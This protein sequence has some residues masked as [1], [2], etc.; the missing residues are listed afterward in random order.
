MLRS[1]IAAAALTLA[2]SACRPDLPKEPP[3]S[4][5]VTAVFDPTAAVPQIPLPNDLVFLSNPNSVCPPPGND[6]KSGPACAQAELLTAFAGRFPSDQEIP[7]TIDFVQTNFN[8]DGTTSPSAP[9]LDFATFTPATLIVKSTTDPVGDVELDPIT[10][11]DYHTFADHATLSL[12]RKGR[13][14]WAPGSYAVI[15]RGGP[16]GVQTTDKVPVSASQVFNLIEQGLDMTDPKNIGLLKAQAGS[17]A[18]AL[19]QGMQ[20]NLL[21]GLYKGKLFPFADAVFPHQEMAIAT[22]FS[23][24]S[25][26]T[27]VTIDPAR[28]LAP[29]PFDLLRDLK[30]GKLSAL[31]AC[32]FAGSKLAADGTCPTPAAAG[33]L[34]LDGFSTTG[35]IL[36]PTSDLI[37]AA[38]VTKDTL[39]LYDL[40]DPNNPA[41]VPPET[42]II[43]PCEFGSACSPTAVS[44]VIAL[45]PAGA[46]AGD[47]T[48]VLRTKPLKDNTDYAVVITTGIKDKAGNSIG[49]GTVAKVLGF[50]NPVSVGGKSALQGI[51]DATAASLEA[52]RNQLKPVF[53]KV[54]KSEVALAY[55]FHT[56][57]ILGQA[58][59]LAALPYSTP[60]ETA[61]TGPLPD[62]VPT[63][64]D[65]FTKFGV[66]AGVPSGDINEILETDI[67]T[68]NA[69]DPAT[70]AFLADPTKAVPE[71]IHVLVATPKTAAKACAFN[72]ALKCAPMVVFRHGL[73]RGRA[74]LLLIAEAFASA[75][76][77]T[78]A[79]DA[80]K[81][82]DRALCTSGTTGTT[83]VAGG[84][85]IGGCNPGI[86]C[87]TDLPAGAQ[88]DAA[89]PGHCADGKLFKLGLDG[90]P[91][92]TPDKDGIPA[93]SSNYLISANFFRTRDTLR[94]DLIDESQLVRALAFVP[95]ATG[96]PSTVFAHMAAQGLVID[97]GTVYYVGQS[98]GSIQGSMNVATNPR[99]LKAAFNVGGGTLVDIF[100]QAPRFKPATDQLLAGLGIV[101][102][103][104]QFLQF[105]VVAKTVL[106]PA[107]PINFAGHLT[108]NT[109]ANLLMPGTLQPKRAVLAQIADCD[110]TVPNPFN[111]VFASN[112]GVSPLPTGDAFFTSRT[113]GT[114]Q[115]FISSA[116]QTLA[117]F[118]ACQSGV[119][120]HGFLLD[121]STPGAATLTGKAQ[122]DIAAFLAAG[123]NPPSVES[124]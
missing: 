69:L 4:P 41:L 72:A 90:T 55:T 115:V 48:S 70:G 18:K 24:G 107:D 96:T 15:V 83:P 75:G 59:Q 34:A 22:T 63:V 5:V 66:P 30:T 10:D 57:T 45:Q 1:F 117:G 84:L 89:P 103:T 67:T 74:D 98:L 12:H 23:I 123:A 124:P 100:T 53:A 20:L 11:A 77:V 16:D 114:F 64:A 81:H 61:A 113:P 105:L 71:T 76:M 60:P 35:A 86:A 73:G 112:I 25:T 37:Q 3:S 79:I 29:L 78:V 19:E 39:Q 14:P 7:V 44:P 99:I 68:F 26:V 95:S 49:P 6:S 36:A 80:A 93:I 27:N 32:T 46:T 116:T 9:K 21:I 40:T 58:N 31:A 33:F 56:Q 101:P 87:V 2:M 104:A 106:D 110:D 111:L 51:D 91:V 47:P 28:G 82:G 52:M 85:P 43:Q 94:Q 42:L 54:T 118:L 102:G 38:T 109:L 122:A 88:G 13:E 108:D 92:T 50:T 65:E 120:K 97:P 119:V 17:T 8:A 121:P 62:P